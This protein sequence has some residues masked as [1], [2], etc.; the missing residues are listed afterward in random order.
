MLS[1]LACTESECGQTI[2]TPLSETG[3]LANPTIILMSVNALQY[4]LMT[5]ASGQMRNVLKHTLS[6]VTQV[7]IQNPLCIFIT[8]SVRTSCHTEFINV[9]IH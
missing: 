9:F 2:A 6:S 1:S 4:H 8:L 3:D 5:Q 7:N